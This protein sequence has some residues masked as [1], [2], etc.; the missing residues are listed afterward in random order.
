LTALVVDAEQ[1]RQGIGT[2]L[3]DEA[4]EWTRLTGAQCI[5]AELPTVNYPAA[6]FLHT[7]GF[8]FCGYN[9]ALDAAGVETMLFFVYPLGK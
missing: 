9:D 4:K 6:H 7:Q 5:M 2:A 8:R 1:R 3:L